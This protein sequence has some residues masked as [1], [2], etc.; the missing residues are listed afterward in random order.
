MF[1][2]YKSTN[3]DAEGWAGCG[4]CPQVVGAYLRT[5]ETHAL[6]EAVGDLLPFKEAVGDQCPLKEAEGELLLFKDV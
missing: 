1:Y 4:G 5:C 2:W 6:K 3:N